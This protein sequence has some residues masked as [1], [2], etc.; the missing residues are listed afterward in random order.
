MSSATSTSSEF[1]LRPVSNDPCWKY[2]QYVSANDKSRIKCILCNNYVATGGLARFRMHLIRMPNSNA[3]QCVNATTEIKKE[4]RDYYDSQ[5]KASR[6]TA[7]YQDPYLRPNTEEED[8]DD[9]VP[10]E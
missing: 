7:R 1:P 6:V 2:G 4:I 8:E 5:F 9:V 10:L 3:R